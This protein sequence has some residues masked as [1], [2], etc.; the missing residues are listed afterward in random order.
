M[1]TDEYLK[2]LV[3]DIHSV[4]VATLG[5]DGRPQTRAIDMMLFDDNGI[6]FLTAKGKSFRE[7]LKSQGFAAVSA[8]KG[9]VSLSLRGSVRSIG[10]EKLDLILEKNKYMQRIYPHRTRGAL[11]VFC[12]FDAQG[13][14]FDISDPAHIRRD[15]FTIGSARV[16]D[17][18]YF[19]GEDCFGCDKCL[20]V[21]PQGCIDVSHTPAVIDRHGCLGCGQCAEVCPAHAVNW[22]T[23]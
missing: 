13:E 2:I 4:T 18:G 19:I 22:R 12:L 5:A 11:E 23:L 3:D 17:V 7:Q 1:A 6:Y 21:C 9:K 15:S 10:Q 16:C 8:V 14:Y 20:K